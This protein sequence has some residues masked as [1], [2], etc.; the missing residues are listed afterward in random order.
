[1]PPRQPLKLKST[2]R[3]TGRRTA[4]A[5]A[6][7]ALAEVAAS[8][9]IAAEPAPKMLPA[10]KQPSLSPYP[11]LSMAIHMLEI[12]LKNAEGERK[13]LLEKWMRTLTKLQAEMQAL[14]KMEALKHRVVLSVTKPN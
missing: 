2:A 1:M 9:L 12:C 10:P 14:H 5:L 3:R 6:A 7:S 11:D 13:T 8:L 4:P